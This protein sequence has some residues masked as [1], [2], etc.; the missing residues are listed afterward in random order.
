MKS[1]FIR[2]SLYM[3]LIFCCFLA[4][5]CHTDPENNSTENSELRDPQREK[6]KEFTLCVGGQLID[7]CSSDA[8]NRRRMFSSYRDVDG[9][10]LEIRMYVEWDGGTTGC[11]YRVDGVLTINQDGSDPDFRRTNTDSSP[12]LCLFRP[13]CVSNFRPAPCR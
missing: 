1:Q 8:N 6:V 13:G 3:A 7:N 9:G 5:D 11:H 10:R 12:R 2:Y 4:A